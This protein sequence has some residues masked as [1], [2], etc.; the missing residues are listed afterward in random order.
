MADSPAPTSPESKEKPEGTPDVGATPET[1]HKAGNGAQK[2]IQELVGKSKQKDETIQQLRAGLIDDDMK[3]AIATLFQ[4]H[5]R[6]LQQEVSVLRMA[7]EL[8]FN[9][10][11]AMAVFD[12]EQKMSLSRDE[13]IMLAAK[14]NPELF[15]QKVAAPRQAPSS[16]GVPWLPPLLNTTG[17]SADMP[18]RRP[19]SSDQM[20]EEG[21][22]LRGVHRRN[23][24][25]SALGQR[26][27][28]MR[29]RGHRI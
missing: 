22:K 13:A 6:P 4:E 8:G 27:E 5:S 12:L 24:A 10:K 19:P 23:A 20:V 9:E 15:P 1:E 16:Q 28:E 29:Q 14:R 2:R 7:N 3:D 25:L 18:E 17:S 21:S 11:Q 26:L